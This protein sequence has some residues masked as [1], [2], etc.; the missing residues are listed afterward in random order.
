MQTVCMGVGG[1]MKK[2]EGCRSSSG[3]GTWAAEL[4]GLQ[5]K[6]NK[7]WSGDVRNFGDGLQRLAENGKRSTKDG[8][9]YRLDSTSYAF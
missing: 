2:A 3:K 7:H 5:R 9:V 4:S 1:V 8:K 6:T